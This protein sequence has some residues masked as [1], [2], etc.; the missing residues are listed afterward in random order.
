MGFRALRAPS[1]NAC[2]ERIPPAS[3][4]SSARFQGK[5]FFGFGP[6]KTKNALLAPLQT[7]PSSPEHW[8]HFE[9]SREFSLVGRLRGE[10]TLR[11]T[12]AV[13]SRPRG[14]V[15]KVACT[16]GSS[17]HW[18]ILTNIFRERRVSC[19]RAW[20]IF[21]VVSAS[22]KPRGPAKKWPILANGAAR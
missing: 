7:F 19:P 10:W 9:K 5:I 16:R 3:R 18:P 1:T 11:W 12:G 22:S 2:D 4:E 13:A 6:P 17:G 8:F 20:G 21:F 15:G 14:P